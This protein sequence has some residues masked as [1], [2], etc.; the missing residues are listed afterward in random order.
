MNRVRAL[1][2]LALLLGCANKVVSVQT[3]LVTSACEGAQP[4]DGVT[5]L[6]FIV[7]GDGIASPIVQVFPI[8]AHAGSVTDIPP[9]THRVLEVRGYQGDPS[10]GG[11]VLSRGRSMPFDVPS[12]VPA[13]GVPSPSATIVMRRVNTFVAPSVPDQSGI[14]TQMS[15]PRAGHTATLLAD[16]RVLIA[17][18]YTINGGQ[19]TT[20]ASAEIFDPVAGTFSPAADLGITDAQQT[21]TPTP[22]AFHTGT[23]LPGGQ[24]LLAGGEVEQ[25]GAPVPLD[26]ALV[27]DPKTNVYGVVQL[28][29]ARSQAAAAADSAGHVLLV[30]G[31]GQGGAINGSVEWYD[32]STARTG[33]GADTVSRL[34]VNALAIGDGSQIAVVGGTDGTAL[35]PE[36]LLFTFSGGAFV[37]SAG[38][39][40]RE[41][42]RSAAIAPFGSGVLVVGGFSDPADPA[43]NSLASTEVLSGNPVSDVDGPAIAPRGDACAAALADGQVLTAGGNAADFTGTP[44]S[45]DAAELITTSPDG[46]ATALG[47]PPLPAPRMQHTCTTLADGSVLILG[48]LLDSGGSQTV[49]S[50]ATIF[51]PAPR[52]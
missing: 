34:H 19:I 16:G 33:V 10:Q 21:F 2:V 50:D 47:M 18:G 3:T 6:K 11:V 23:L 8:N 36:T 37:S 1:C 12:A 20:L 46:S 9:G 41:P 14:C 13:A 39:T 25:G 45:T 7:T 30:G 27:Y 17:G 52:D 35:Q 29:S 38:P 24:V 43:E 32:A 51:M 48:G 42:R 40:L 22:R 31:V 5:H 49:L 44:T 15:T 4:L 28:A 26:N